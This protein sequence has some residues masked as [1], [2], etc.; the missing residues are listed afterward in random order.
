[1]V[2]P[3]P[4]G[5]GLAPQSF[6]NADSERTLVPGGNKHLRGDVQPDPDGLDQ[7]RRGLAR[8]GLEKS[9]VDFNLVV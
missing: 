5:I 4:A 3:D 6:A 7:L 2:F 8:L 1:M 9:A